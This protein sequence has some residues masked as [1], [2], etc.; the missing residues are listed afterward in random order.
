MDKSLAQS[1]ISKSKPVSNSSV[2]T[3][4]IVRTTAIKN[5]K[6]TR[7][8]KIRAFLEIGKWIISRVL[9][10][11]VLSHSVWSVM[12]FWAK[13]RSPA[14]KGITVFVKTCNVYRTKISNQQ[15]RTKKYRNT[16]TK[17]KTTANVFK[18]FNDRKSM[19]YICQL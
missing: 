9:Y 17:I 13:I 11:I 8:N 14:L 19:Y 1:T 3:L 6:K 15:R 18:V 16:R 4:H 10:L 2:I 7:N 12:K 5:A